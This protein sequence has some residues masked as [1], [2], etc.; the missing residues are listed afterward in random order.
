MQH[1]ISKP[2][3]VPAW[4][5]N[6]SH[7]DWTN[8][9]HLVPKNKSL[10]PVALRADWKPQFNNWDGRILFLAQD[11]CPPHVIEERIACGEPQPWRYGQ[12]GEKG[13]RTNDRLFGFASTIPG[14]KLCGSAAANMLDNQPGMSRK[15]NGF[16]SGPLQAFCQR[17]FC[18][19]LGSMPHVEWESSIKH[20][21]IVTATLPMRQCRVQF[22]L[23]KNIVH[24]S[25][26]YS[27]CDTWAKIIAYARSKRGGAPDNL[28]R[29]SVAIPQVLTARGWSNAGD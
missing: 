25:P 3:S 5:R 13:S 15:L 8:V 6:F 2:P 16:E 4:I 23:D 9:F 1:A 14:G 10:Y 24:T 29:Q 21:R 27:S 12:Y 28:P 20:H 7:P 17:V 22:I 26:E 11:G 19:V 18:W